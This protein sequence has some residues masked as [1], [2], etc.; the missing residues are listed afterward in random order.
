MFWRG[1]LMEVAGNFSSNMGSDCLAYVS[2]MSQTGAT[3]SVAVAV[4]F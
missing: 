4:I 1:F 2:R 3:L